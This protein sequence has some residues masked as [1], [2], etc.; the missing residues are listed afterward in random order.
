MPKPSD[1]FPGWALIVPD[2]KT[3]DWHIAWHEIFDRK[4]QAVAFAV[5]NQWPKPWRAVRASLTATQPAPPKHA[6]Q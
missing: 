4:K 6:V 5:E 1:S 3:G 2:E